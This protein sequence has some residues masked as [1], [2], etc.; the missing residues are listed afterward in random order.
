MELLYNF[1]VFFFC[2]FFF[3][4]ARRTT[5]ECQ[6]C[7]SC[8]CVSD[9]MVDRLHV[10]RAPFVRKRNRKRY[11]YRSQTFIFVFYFFFLRTKTKW[12]PKRI[13]D[14]WQHTRNPPQMKRQFDWWLDDWNEQRF[15]SRQRHQHQH[16]FIGELRKHKKKQN[17]IENTSVFQLNWWL[18][19]VLPPPQASTERAQKGLVNF[20]SRTH[21]THSRGCGGYAGAFTVKLYCRPYSFIFIQI[22]NKGKKDRF[23]GGVPFVWVRVVGPMRQCYKNRRKRSNRKKVEKLRTFSIFT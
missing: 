14:C 2:S 9:S 19:V 20:D 7:L 6:K 3:L 23:L 13:I 12:K 8:V 18:T 5:I 10:R 1:F 17:Q 15:V 11:I 4:G 21:Y 16:S 22:I